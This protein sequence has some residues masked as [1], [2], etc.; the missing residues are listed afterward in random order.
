MIDG[1]LALQVIISAIN[2]RSARMKKYILENKQLNFI[3][4][5]SYGIYLYHYVLQPVY[6]GWIG[7]MLQRHPAL[8]QVIGQYY[9]SYAIKLILLLLISWLSYVLI[10]TPILNLKKQFSYKIAG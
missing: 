4:K 9:F 8:P 6:D 1:V 2:N 3:G 7:R 5:I 10:E